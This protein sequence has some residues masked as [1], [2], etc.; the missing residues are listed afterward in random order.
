MCCTGDSFIL[1]R[2]TSGLCLDLL[3]QAA[4]QY[5]WRGSHQVEADPGQRKAT[6]LPGRIRR[7]AIQQ[8]EEFDRLAGFRELTRHFVG[9]QAPEGM[10][11]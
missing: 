10:A 5:L 6:R 8:T 9:N 4:K 11:D 2:R 1:A 3:V 7:F